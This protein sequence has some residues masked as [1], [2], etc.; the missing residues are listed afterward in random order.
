MPSAAACADVSGPLMFGSGGHCVHETV[1]NLENGSTGFCGAVRVLYVI[2]AQALIGT[3]HVS[4]Q[5]LVMS[6]LVEAVAVQCV[7][8]NVQKV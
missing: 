5:D 4:V 3:V 7:F 1:S 8:S 6:G 2:C